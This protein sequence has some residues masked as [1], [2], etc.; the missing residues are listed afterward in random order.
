LENNA[1]SLSKMRSLVVAVLACAAL[2]VELA[3]VD[4]SDAP[5]DAIVDP[6]FSAVDESPTDLQS[7]LH[8]VPLK[9]IFDGTP[10][11]TDLQWVGQISVGTPPQ[12]L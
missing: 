5:K 8:N 7:E 2:A 3:L 1:S 11:G 12:I 6:N 4:D 10:E 9:S